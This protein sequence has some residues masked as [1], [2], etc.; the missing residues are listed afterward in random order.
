MRVGAV[1]VNQVANCLNCSYILVIQHVECFT[2]QFKADAIRDVRP[3]R[4]PHIH[5]DDT[6]VAKRISS[7]LGQ[8]GVSSIS[9]EARAQAA[10]ARAGICSAKNDTGL[11]APLR[12]RSRTRDT[13]D[14]NR[15]AREYLRSFSSSKANLSATHQTCPVNSHLAPRRQVH[16]DAMLSEPRCCPKLVHAHR[17]WRCRAPVSSQLDRRR[18]CCRQRS[19]RFDCRLWRANM[20]NRH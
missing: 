15:T 10:Y 2:L 4:D 9:I 20:C 8:N 14:R 13:P 5:V 11:A 12:M 18:R 17:I 3:F 19:T 16:A 1:V 7:H 6:R